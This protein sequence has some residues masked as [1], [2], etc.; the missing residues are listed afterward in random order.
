MATSEGMQTRGQ[1]GSVL[2][3]Q[4]VRDLTL[5]AGQHPQGL[6]H[7]S[8]ASGLV[9]V[10]K[11]AY[12]VADDSLHMGV[13]K[14]PGKAPVQLLRLFE[15]KLPASHVARKALKPDLEALV[16]LPPTLWCPFGALLA[17]G[18]GSTRLR[19]R[20]VLLLLDI[21]GMAYGLDAL[22]PG[23]KRLDLSALYAML[24]TQFA[25]L[26]IEGAFVSGGKLRLLQ[27]GN[28]SHP[29]SACIS[30]DLAR[31]MAWITNPQRTLP[32]PSSVQRID[33]GQVQGVP[34]CIT[35]AT[36]LHYPGSRGA[37]VFSAVAEDT[38]NSYADGACVASAVGVMGARGR[39]RQLHFLQGAPKVE[40]LSARV[41]GST[42]TLTMVT[43]ADDPQ[44][45]SQLLTL[46]VPLL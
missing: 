21:K 6:R 9:C 33:L 1:R 40:G 36:A 26:N 30:F 34:L 18:S 13:F 28:Q 10:Q 3:P 42:L 43:D 41:V 15:G 11:Y 12:V 20:G 24:R 14:H 17:L 23:S 25:D 45:A 2:T 5:G 32:R 22:S 19:E 16:H 35:D 7:L 46:D 39:L 8:A 27:R 4:W 29:H 38:Q 44:I 37:W 31:L